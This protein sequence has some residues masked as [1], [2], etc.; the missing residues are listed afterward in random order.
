MVTIDDLKQIMAD[1]VI[2]LFDFQRQLAKALAERD[3]L[4][5]RLDVMIAAK[6]GKPPEEKES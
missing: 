5:K 1:H 3:A 6:A 4:Q 2:Q